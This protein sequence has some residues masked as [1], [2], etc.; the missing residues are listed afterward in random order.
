MSSSSLGIRPLPP[1]CRS[2]FGASTPGS[3]GSLRPDGAIRQVPFRPRGFPPPRRLPPHR[4]CGFVAPRCRLWGSARFLLPASVRARRLAGAPSHSPRRGSYP[5]KSS[6][7]QQ[8]YRITAA[9]ALVPL[10]PAPLARTCPAGAERPSSGSRGHRRRPAP[11]RA[12][13]RSG[14]VRRRGPRP[15]ATRRIAAGRGRWL[16]LS[17][18]RAG[19]VGS[20]VHR[21]SE[22]GRE[23]VRTARR[24]RSPAVPRGARS[25]SAGR[26]WR[27]RPRATG[28]AR[29]ERRVGALPW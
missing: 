29:P 12:E 26:G 8:P 20:V 24:P 6:P 17:P 10:L 1:L 18:R 27:W 22:E 14:A 5:S 19:A 21:P 3:R 13:T 15:L 28:V 7:H 9:V 25:A 4:G 23:P 11:C 2:T 16:R